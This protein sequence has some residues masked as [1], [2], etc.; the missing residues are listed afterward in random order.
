[1][2]A[3]N[4][5]FIIIIENHR[6]KT[7]AEQLCLVVKNTLAEATMGPWAGWVFQF[8]N[9]SIWPLISGGSPLLQPPPSL[10]CLE[11]PPTSKAAAAITET[12]TKLP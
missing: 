2:W 7:E 10:P 3:Y 8:T 12:L 5:N 6:H 9:C 11:L 1:M 4:N